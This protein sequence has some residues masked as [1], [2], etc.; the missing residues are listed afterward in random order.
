MFWLTVT[1]AQLNGRGLMARLG[2]AGYMAWSTRK[3]SVMDTGV[4]GS[5][6]PLC[7]VRLQPW[8]T[9]LAF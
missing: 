1:R 4:S 7:S 3:Q 2:A 8:R 9:P 6:F 5:P